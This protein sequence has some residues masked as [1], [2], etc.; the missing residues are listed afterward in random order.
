VINPSLQKALPFDPIADFERA[1]REKH[2]AVVYNIQNAEPVGDQ[3]DRI[4]TLHGLGMR[5]VQL[6]YSLRTR[7]GDGCLEKNDGGIS[8]FGEALIAKLNRSRMMMDVS[9]ARPRTAADSVAAS[10]ML[11]VASH[12]AA[13][14]I[15][16]R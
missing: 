6:T 2:H 16:V 7:F 1:Y 14:A 8:R 4:D 9:P 11:V 5:S 13:R 3:L 10:T 12:T 15:A